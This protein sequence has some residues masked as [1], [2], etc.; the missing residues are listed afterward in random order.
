ML[1]NGNF[2]IIGIG[3]H[4]SIQV[5]PECTTKRSDRMSKH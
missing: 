3:M 2:Q 5:V 4:E 1:I